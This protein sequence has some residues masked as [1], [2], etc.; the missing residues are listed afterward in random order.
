MRGIGEGAETY[1]VLGICTG[2]LISNPFDKT[3]THETS[4]MIMYEKPTLGNIQTQ[5]NSQWLILSIHF[6]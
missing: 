5:A 4:E 1:L 6:N 2:Y 3:C